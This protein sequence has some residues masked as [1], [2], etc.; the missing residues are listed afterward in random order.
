MIWYLIKSHI[1]YA[2]TD[3]LQ[4]PTV[5][6]GSPSKSIRFFSLL[7]SRIR[8]VVAVV[9]LMVVVR[10]KLRSGS[11]VVADDDDGGD[12]DGDDDDEG[13]IDVDEYEVLRLAVTLTA[14]VCPPRTPD[15][16][17]ARPVPAARQR[18]SRRPARRSQEIVLLER[19]GT[20]S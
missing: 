11:D 3:Y 12:G 13:D 20:G 1:S 9:V 8:S 17:R 14:S 19:G 18:R 2:N 16:Q 10:L 4:C 15:C 6:P 7:L 5:V